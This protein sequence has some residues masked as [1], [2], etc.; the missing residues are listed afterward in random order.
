MTKQPPWV[1]DGEPTCLPRL[2]LALNT[3]GHEVNCE[4]P[5]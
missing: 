1:R 4:E 3:A 2:R 5:R